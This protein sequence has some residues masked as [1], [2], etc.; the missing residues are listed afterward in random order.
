[1]SDSQSYFTTGGLSP[2]SSSWRQAPWDSR[3]SNFIFQLNICGYSPY[4]T[5]SLRKG[6]VYRLQLPLVLASGVILGSESRGTHGRILPSQI[7]DFPNLEGQVPVFI[8][9]RNR[10]GRLYPPA[11]G[12]L[13]ITS[14]DSQ[15]YSGG[16]RFR[17]HA[18]VR[19]LGWCP[20]YITP[21]HGQ[22]RK[23]RFQ[24][25]FYCCMRIRCRGNGFP[26]RCLVMAVYSCL[27]KSVA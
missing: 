25:F 10:V 17:L 11:Q 27:L 16:I 19:P 23:H 22:R 6:W 18:R 2:I 15:G 26:S 20:R 21:W 1:V 14:Y 13:F 9:P 4:V 12:S 8:S 7:R 3:C 24:L 5:L